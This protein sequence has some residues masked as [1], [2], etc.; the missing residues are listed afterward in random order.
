[1]C[2]KVIY[3][4]SH[5]RIDECMRPLIRF[6]NSNG[7]KTCGSCCGHS[8]YPM[9]VIVKTPSF[10]HRGEWV[11]RELL[12]GTF[13]PRWRKYYRRDSKGHYYIPEVSNEVK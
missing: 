6:L 4:T 7:W 8:R 9:T 1:M 13:I 10:L 5:K 3:K 12:S 2:R 11:Y